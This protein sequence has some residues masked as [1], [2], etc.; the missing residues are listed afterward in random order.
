LEYR[1]SVIREL[2]LSEHQILEVLAEQAVEASTWKILADRFL[3]EWILERARNQLLEEHV[4]E[5]RV[6]LRRQDDD[7]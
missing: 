7:L 4:A 6:G 2:A 1:D 5:L 3:N